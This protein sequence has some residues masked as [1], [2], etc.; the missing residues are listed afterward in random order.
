MAAASMPA[1][2]SPT[3]KAASLMKANGLNTLSAVGEP[4]DKDSQ[5]A[6]LRQRW[7]KL[8]LA[9]DCYPHHAFSKE[10]RRNICTRHGIDDATLEACLVAYV[11]PDALPEAERRAAALAHA[12]RV[13]E[14]VVAPAPKRKAAP[15][16][17]RKGGQCNR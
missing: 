12:L 3:K 1:V 6:L 7:P 9:L 16:G 11:H 4:L 14:E 17:H 5:N 13:I 15:K 2:L 10:G 8:F